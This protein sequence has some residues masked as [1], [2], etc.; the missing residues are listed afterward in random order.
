MLEVV[1]YS[2]DSWLSEL[3]LYD[4]LTVAAFTQPTAR[5]LA[6][7]CKRNSEK[8]KKRSRFKTLKSIKTNVN[9]FSFKILY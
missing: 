5:S 2:M 3:A 9:W 4:G 1:T 8:E 6:N 7:L